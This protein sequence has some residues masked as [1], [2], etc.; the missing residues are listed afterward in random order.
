MGLG[1]FAD[2]RGRRVG[3]W[4]AWQ[5]IGGGVFEWG[6][7]VDTPKEHYGVLQPSSLPLADK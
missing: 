3:G 7:G 6:R 4:G 5:E 2:L 1:Q